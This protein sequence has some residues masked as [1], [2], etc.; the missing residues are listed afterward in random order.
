MGK[1]KYEWLGP[2]VV[3]N[4]YPSGT[5]ELEDHK[6]RSFV[7]NG[8]MLKHYYMGEPEATKVELLHFKDAK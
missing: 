2:L 3:S 5:I 8:K 4:V 7:V 1:I 6:N